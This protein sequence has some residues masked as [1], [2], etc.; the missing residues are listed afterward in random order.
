MNKFGIDQ[1]ALVEQF[2]QAAAKGAEQ[3]RKAVHDATLQALQGRELSL[4]NIRSAL[5]GVTQAV[6]AGAA[7]AGVSQLDA[8]IET[9]IAGMDEAL[10][11]AVDANRIALQQ[12]VDQGVSLR[13]THLKKALGDLEKMEDTLFAAIQK[14]A[15][16]ASGTMAGP[17]AQVL[18]RFTSGATLTGA[19]ATSSVEGLMAQMQTAMRE[20]RA[21]SL[22]GAQA[23]AE[24]YTALASGV[25]IGMADALRQ[26]QA[27]A[28][29]KK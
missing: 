24:S 22:K 10:L 23:L 16:S 4:R 13:E 3:M 7:N 1:Q 17:W 25:L 6:G 26:G 18:E 21:A 5:A 8:M 28:P 11:K 19:K 12:L 2:T 29:R 15:A 20:S 9:G 14:A 27:K